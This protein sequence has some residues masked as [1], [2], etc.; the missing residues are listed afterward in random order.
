MESCGH[1]GCVFDVPNFC[2]LKNKF[3]NSHKGCS[4]YKPERCINHHI[5]GLCDKSGLFCENYHCPEFVKT[6][7]SKD[8]N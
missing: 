7:I 4:D 8:N 3:C 5:S 2:E 1:L 6:C